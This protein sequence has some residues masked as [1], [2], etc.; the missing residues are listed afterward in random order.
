MKIQTKHFMKMSIFHSQRSPS[1]VVQEWKNTSAQWTSL[2]QSHSRRSMRVS[3]CRSISIES[4]NIF[5]AMPFWF[6]ANRASQSFQCWR[7]THTHTCKDAH[8]FDIVLKPTGLNATKFDLRLFARFTRAIFTN[9]QRAKSSFRSS[10]DWVMWKFYPIIVTRCLHLQSI[11][12]ALWREFSD[13]LMRHFTKISNYRI[14]HGC[15]MTMPIAYQR[16][17]SHCEHHR[18][19]KNRLQWK[20]L[21]NCSDVSTRKS[22]GTNGK[23]SHRSQLDIKICAANRAHSSTPVTIRNQHRSFNKNQTLTTCFL[24][25]FIYFST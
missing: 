6:H 17:T 21:S 8:S 15:V 19:S 10:I 25:P 5:E 2:Y 12:T 23:P 11:E 20:L 14:K 16:F 4:V 7:P 1:W 13:I 22:T 9:V 24:L 18:W 3:G